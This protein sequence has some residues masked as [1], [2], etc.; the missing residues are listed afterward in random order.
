MLL[1]RQEYDD[2]GRTVTSWAPNIRYAELHWDDDFEAQV[3]KVYHGKEQAEPSC[4]VLHDNC[5]VYLC[6]DDGKTIEVLRR[7]RAPGH[8]FRSGSEAT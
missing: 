2:K 4:I 7:L 3:L 5:G 8:E 6:N 1:K